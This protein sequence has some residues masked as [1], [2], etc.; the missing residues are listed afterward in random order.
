MANILIIDDDAVF[1]EMVE[2][3][4]IRAGHQASVHLGPFGGTI[5]ARKEGLDLIILDVFMPGLD[6]GSLLDLMRRDGA[7]MR[8]RV[9]FCSSMDATPLRELA[10]RHHADGWIP[11]SAGRQQL[12]GYVDQVLQRSSSFDTRGRSKP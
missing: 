7:L 11:K 2:Q 9:I 3:R 8:P 6:G 12:L 4:L 1:S 10:A 5:A